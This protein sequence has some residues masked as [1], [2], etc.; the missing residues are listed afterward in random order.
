MGSYS[1]DSLQKM[2]QTLAYH[3]L[4]EGPPLLVF[5]FVVA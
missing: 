5:V 2:S 1:S 3:D 4:D